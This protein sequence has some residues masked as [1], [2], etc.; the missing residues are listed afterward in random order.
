MHKIL[1]LAVLC[2]GLLLLA[3]C[4]GPQGPEIVPV[5]GN[6]TVD[7]KPLKNIRIEFW[8][9]TEGPNS[10]ALTDE[11]GHFVLMTEEVEPRKGAVKGMHRLAARDSEV[12][13]KFVGRSEEDNSSGKAP[14]I[15][16]TYS[17]AMFS[18]VEQ[19]I[20]GPITDLKI[21]L[22]P[23]DVAE[24][25]AAAKAGQAAATGKSAP[26]PAVPAGGGRRDE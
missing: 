26:A 18:G 1:N 24:V 20:S 19:S 7:G 3:G 17:N 21:E 10:V 6:I 15:S 11:Q 8:P 23:Y 14:R 25:E 16:V 22:K 9:E 5:E 2:G 12:V 13:S 4:P